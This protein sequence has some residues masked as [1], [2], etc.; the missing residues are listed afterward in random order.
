MSIT[1]IEQHTKIHGAKNIG[2]LL[3]PR[4]ELLMPQRLKSAVKMRA[5]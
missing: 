1:T 5:E 3:R 2:K 4:H